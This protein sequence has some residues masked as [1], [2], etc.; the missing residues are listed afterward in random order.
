MGRILAVDHGDRRIGVAISDPTRLIAQPL[1]T[2][3][4]RRGRRPPFAAIQELIREW[5][6]ERVVVGLPLESSGHEGAQAERAR[7]FGEGL[8]RRAGVPVEYW[9]E[10]LTSVRA[11]REIEAMDLPRSSRR[12]KERVDAMA[13]TLILQAYLDSRADAEEGQA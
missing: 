2:I 12:E 10:R 1:P 8:A 9:D 3:V 5:E 7:L 13:A 11:R 4:R 6:V